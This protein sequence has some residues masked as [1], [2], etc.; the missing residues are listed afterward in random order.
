MRYIQS[1]QLQSSAA[2]GS[3]AAFAQAKDVTLS[4]VSCNGK[5]GITLHLRLL[6]SVNSHLL[7]QSFSTADQSISYGVHTRENFACPIRWIQFPLVLEGSEADSHPI[8]LE[9]NRKPMADEQSMLRRIDER[10][11]ILK[12]RVGKQFRN[13]VTQCVFRQPPFNRPDRAA[14]F[15]D[16]AI[17]H[18]L[19]RELGEY[20]P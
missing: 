11:Y 18:K 3:G 13:R 14:L 19:I 10:A 20:I 2:A 9:R 16:W 6:V 8:F 4:D 5:L 15:M 7:T 17:Q 1:A 12:P